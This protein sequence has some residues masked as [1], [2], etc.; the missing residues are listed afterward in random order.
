MITI[1]HHRIKF[2]DP[3]AATRQ[4]AYDADLSDT[5]VMKTI[6]DMRN[7]IAM[8]NEAHAEAETEDLPT[9]QT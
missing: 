7:R 4:S 9:L 6:E 1:G 5:T 8:K 3:H 2:Y